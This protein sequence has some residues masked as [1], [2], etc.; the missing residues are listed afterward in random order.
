MDVLFS[1]LIFQ[2]S[3]SLPLFIHWDSLQ[4]EVGTLFSH[5][6]DCMTKAVAYTCTIK[7][8]TVSLLYGRLHDKNILQATP[9]L[10]FEN[11]HRYMS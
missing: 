6:L 10:F 9:S 1:L 4:Y 7:R 5:V 8:E 11:P 2:I 3:T